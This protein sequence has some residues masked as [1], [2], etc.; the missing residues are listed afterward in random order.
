LHSLRGAWNRPGVRGLAL[1]RSTIQ[2]ALEGPEHSMELSSQPLVLDEIGQSST[3][4]WYSADPLPMQK[5]LEN[6][7]LVQALEKTLDSRLGVAARVRLSARWYA[8]AFWAS[9]RDDAVLALG[10]SL[11]AL[12]GSKSGLP[13]RVMRD[14]YALLDPS[15]SSRQERAR[16]YDEIFGVR[17][18]I[19]HGGTS[20]RIGESGF[21]RRV[22]DDVTWTAWRLLDIEETFGEGLASDLDQLFDQLR[23]GIVA[24]P[25]NAD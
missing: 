8:E 7:D 5:L 18:A 12:I 17:S 6:T 10:V 9:E 11:D 4:H 24:W 22:Q 1:D 14:R 23:W 3:V 2:S 19:A 20:S 13:G 21:V 15:P 25:A 16:R